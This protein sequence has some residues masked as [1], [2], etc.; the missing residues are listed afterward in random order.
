MSI[1]LRVRATG[2]YSGLLL[3]LVLLAMG[4]S[5]PSEQ[6]DSYGIDLSRVPI[7]PEMQDAV[8]AARVSLAAPLRTGPEVEMLTQFFRLRAQIEGIRQRDQAGDELYAAWRT[9]P[10]SFLWIDLANKMNYLLHREVERDSLYQSSA[11]ADTNSGVGNF[12]RGCMSRYGYDQRGEYYRRAELRREELSPLQQIWLHRFLAW[13]E[14]NKGKSEQA[15]ELQL[16]DLDLARATGGC[17][18]EMVLWH[19]IA[20]SLQQ[21]GRLDDAMHAITLAS[22][23]ARKVACKYWDVACQL[24]LVEMLE[25]TQQDEKGGPILE[26]CLRISHDQEFAQLYIQALQYSANLQFKQRQYEADVATRQRLLEYCIATED[27]QSA[28]RVMVNIATTLLLLDE[29]DSCR[30]YF[31]RAREWLEMTGDTAGLQQIPRFEA[32]YYCYIGDYATTDS[33]IQVAYSHR[34]NFSTVD[35]AAHMLMIMLRK[36]MQMGRIE[37]SYRALA[38]LEE[39]RDKLYDDQPQIN[40]LADM[41]ILIADFLAGQGEFHKAAEA[42]DRAAVHLKDMKEIF[43]LWSYHRSRGEL[44]LLRHDPI[45]AREEFTTCLEIACNDKQTSTLTRSR[46]LLG[47]A[48]LEDGRFDEIPA[49]FAEQEAESRRDSRFRIYI[50]SLLFQ[51]IARSRAAEHEQALSYFQR[52]DSLLDSQSPVDL[53]IRLDIELGHSLVALGR[54]RDA[55]ERFLNALENQRHAGT[56]IRVRELQ[57]RN[58]KSDREATAALVGLYLDDPA[59]CAPAPVAEHCLALVDALFRQPTS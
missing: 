14:R 58:Q 11:L 46:F 28:P 57:F 22:E 13:A 20:R 52:A 55:E 39:I 48:L 12:A 10:V 42:L 47:H 21:A 27:S 36:G 51:G 1:D 35:R 43:R 34:A 45:A 32:Q 29:P 6:E 15:A 9:E 41:E 5:G 17:W 2:L 30:A 37:M 59:L 44:A 23:M 38:R 3:L 19:G 49:L 33:L 54:T 25:A 40:R 31:D 18:L 56:G 24:I 53:L 4:C 8:T 7:S 26:N 50:S 16:R